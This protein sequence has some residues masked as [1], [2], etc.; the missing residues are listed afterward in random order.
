MLCGLLAFVLFPT[1]PQGIHH[2]VLARGAGTGNSEPV[3]LLTVADKPV[4]QAAPQAPRPLLPAVTPAMG[5][6]DEFVR[7]LARTFYTRTAPTPAKVREQRV[8]EYRL[9]N[10]DTLFLLHQPVQR[11]S[12]SPSL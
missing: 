10:G 8:S 12:C 11:A 9:S 1:I 6:Q 5:R 3:A 2:M 7:Q 4:T